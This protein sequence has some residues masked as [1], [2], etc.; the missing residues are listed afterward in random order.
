LRGLLAYEE[1]PIVS[2]DVI[3]NP[4]SSIFDAGSTLVVGDR[5]VKT[6][7]WYDNGWGYASRVVDL[8]ERFARLEASP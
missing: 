4:H 6:V 2:S 7:S 8:I 3:G 5:L 1:D